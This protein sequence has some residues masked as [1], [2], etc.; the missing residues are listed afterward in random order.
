MRCVTELINVNFAVRAAVICEILRDIYDQLS[1]MKPERVKI[2]LPK[3]QVRIH[4]SSCDI[5]A[6]AAY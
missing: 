6:V 4:D 1:L 3:S 2:I 5:S